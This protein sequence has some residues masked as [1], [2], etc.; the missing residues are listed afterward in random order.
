MLKK[1]VR[2]SLFIL[3][4]IV[5][6]VAL[7]YAE[8]NWRGR[9]AWVK[10]RRE[11]EARGDSF[12][13][14]SIIP[15]PVPEDQ[16]FAAIPLFAELF[17]KS[18]TNAVLWNAFKLPTSSS[19]Y[20]GWHEGHVE[21]LDAWRT[22]FTN[23][24][25]LAALSKYDPILRQISEASERPYCRFPVRYEDTYAALL[26]H[27]SPL[28]NFARIY[29]LRALTELS[30]GQTDAALDDVQMCLRLADKIKDEPLLISFLVKVAMINLATQPVW[31][32]LGAHRWNDH[33]LSALQA[34][35]ENI[36]QFGSFAK[37]LRGERILEY[38]MMRELIEKPAERA[39][40]FKLFVENQPAAPLL[41]RAAPAGWIYQN[42]LRLD[43]FYAET[44]L[45]TMDFEH[46]R[47]SPK[48]ASVAALQF[49]NKI[50]RPGPYNFLGGLLMPA[51]SATTS[52]AAWSQTTVQEVV[53]ACAL[54]RYRLEYGQLP[55]TL[56]ALVPEFLARVP[57]DVIDGQPLRY[58]RISGDQ[59]VLYSI[60]WNETDDGGQIAWTKDQP[61]RQD[62]QQGDWV[63]FSQPSPS[64]SKPQLSASERK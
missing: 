20:G 47:V 12:E 30:A 35:F 31:E 34:S 38:L 46:Q 55:D 17:P 57:L 42:Q 50:M 61:P 29:H 27:L 6:L 19:F 10:Y 41:F 32:G 36:N 28:R 26:P 2:W 33:H 63:W 21:D 64:A 56:D 54:E 22:W 40:L 37:A 9:H 7:F 49:E 43:R 1:L 13:W 45:P 5:T 58:R 8:E 18:V 16:N 53:V 15:P 62:Q 59:F 23:T 4:C 44:M 51:I 39:G 60:G 3:A 14:S 25:L 48:A 11:R 24:D 52:R